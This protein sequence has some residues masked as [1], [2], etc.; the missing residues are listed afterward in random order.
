MRG[1][2]LSPL[3]SGITAAGVISRA[4]SPALLSLLS[5]QAQPT[6]SRQHRPFSAQA[7]LSTLLSSTVLPLLVSGS[8]RHW[9]KPRAISQEM[10]PAG[11]QQPGHR[12]PAPASPSD[13]WRAAYRT[14][15]AQDTAQ[16][17]TVPH[18]T[19]ERSCGPMR[20]G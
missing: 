15:C 4:Y 12:A 13:T 10:P 1:N 3:G 6:A 5:F 9:L 11:W 8:W 19:P 14:A 7:L 2:Q 20:S 18:S 17:P 16:T